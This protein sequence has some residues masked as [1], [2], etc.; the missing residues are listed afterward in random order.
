VTIEKITA[1]LTLCLLHVF[2]AAACPHSSMSVDRNILVFV[3]VTEHTHTKK[4]LSLPSR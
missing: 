4:L 3:E 1:D 2:V